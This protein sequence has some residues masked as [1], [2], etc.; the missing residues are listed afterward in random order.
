MSKSKTELTAKIRAD[1]D[2]IALLTSSDWNHN[3]HYHRFLMRHVPPRC[4]ESLD[5]GCGTG[6]FSRHLATCSDRVL[7]LDLSPQMI[8][9]A[10]ERS[11]EYPNIDFQI[12]NVR[13]WEFPTERFDCIASIATLHHLPLEEMLYKMKRALK[14]GGSLVILDL[15]REAGLRDVLTSAFAVPVSIGL[16]LVKNGR[17]REP[18]E[19]QEAWAEHGE[20]DSYPTLFQIRQAC[21]NVLPGAQVRKHLL[22]R[23]SLIWRKAA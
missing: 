16:R 19:V 18:R 6:S 1:F 12:T 9:I 21:A 20:N 11:E 14:D 2:R 23:Y 3:S 4:T 7:A 10:R 17:F 5:I 22:W 13:T 8:R 15:F